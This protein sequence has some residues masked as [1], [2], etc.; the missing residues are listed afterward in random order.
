MDGLSLGLLSGRG[1]RIVV[2]LFAGAPRA[3]HLDTE[4]GVISIQTAGATFGHNAGSSTVSMAATYGNSAKTGTRP[5]TGFANPTEVFSSDGPH[6]VFYAPDGT[7]ITPGNFLFATNGGTTLQKPDLSAADGISTIRRD[8]LR[9]S[10][11]PQPHRT[12]QR[13]PLWSCKRDRITRPRK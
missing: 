6:K 4:R 9:S 3:L 10:A 2:V 7:P 12:R 1:R 11:H 8:S 5:F 13:W